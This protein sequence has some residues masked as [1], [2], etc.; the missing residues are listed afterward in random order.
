[1]FS[2]FI[3]PSRTKKHAAAKEAK[4][5]PTKYADLSSTSV[6]FNGRANAS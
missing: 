6:G 2:P 4:P 1:M 5:A 3:C